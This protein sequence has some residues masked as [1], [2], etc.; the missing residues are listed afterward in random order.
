MKTFLLLDRKQPGDERR[1][2]SWAQ[3]SVLTFNL[4]FILGYLIT[5][6]SVVVIT[7]Q[8]DRNLLEFGRFVSSLSKNGR[9][10]NVFHDVL[11]PFLQRSG[12]FSS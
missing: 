3:L 7:I 10:Q 11:A 12:L 9:S 4:L 2:P 6:A 1:D 8:S 5:S